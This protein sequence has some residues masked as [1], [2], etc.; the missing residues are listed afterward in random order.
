MK[1]KNQT[2]GYL[3]PEI[4]SLSATFVY[5]EIFYL[6][7]NGF[8][9][10]PISI[11]KPIISQSD[12][13]LKILQ[14]KTHVLYGRGFWSLSLENLRVLS[15]SPVMYAKTLVMA[16]RDIF[17]VGLFNRIGLGLIFRFMMASRLVGLL[18]DYQCEHLHVHFAHVP[19]DV[20][21]YA[22]SLSKI[23]FTFTSHAND[24]FERGWLLKEKVERS[25]LAIT[26][27]DY[28]RRILEKMGAEG[29]KIH[30]IH[31]GIKSDLFFPSQSQNSARN[32][33]V[34]LG[35]LGRLVEKKGF[36]DLIKA[37]RILKERQIPFIL[38][39]V[40]DGPLKQSLASLRA[41]M[42]MTEEVCFLGAMPHQAISPWLRQLDFFVLAARKDSN[43]DMDGIP[44]VLME[45]MGSGI[46]GVS[47][48]LSGIPEL[49]DHQKTGFLAEPGDPKHLAEILTM[50]IREKFLSGKIISQARRKIKEN[51][52]LNK[53]VD[54]LKQCF[55]RE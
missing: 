4:P 45:A 7:N 6:E 12:E 20:A 5:N 23:P 16:L 19:T 54:L 8:N 44:V 24:I 41:E 3:A 37:C 43:G 34:K 2:I 13:S 48:R 9:V 21:M 22:S 49:V 26:I 36:D 14:A 17:K 25:H 28:N 47:T 38:E 11:H 51:F 33:A 29:Q 46:V 55:L 52:N 40:G 18:R 27:S 30:V 39:I 15:R 50:A 35:S 1:L 32:G 42:G 10:I 31:C 53:N